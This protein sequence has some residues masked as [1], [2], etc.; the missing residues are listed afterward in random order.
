MDD[1][2]LKRSWIRH[3]NLKPFIDPVEA[4]IKIPPPP[5]A[6]VAVQPIK[7]IVQQIPTSEPAIS[8]V[9]TQSKL[10]H[11]IGNNSPPSVPYY[12]A[13]L[14]LAGPTV[15]YDIPKNVLNI[16]PSDQAFLEVPDMSPPKMPT[17]TPSSLGTKWTNIFPPLLV[18]PQSAD[19]PEVH[20]LH[21]LLH[22]LGHHP[23][24]SR[25]IMRTYS[26]VGAY[27]KIK[28]ARIADLE[29]DRGLRRKRTSSHFAA[30]GPGDSASDKSAE[31]GADD[32]RFRGSARYQA[33]TPAKWPDWVPRPQEVL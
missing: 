20:A 8:F 7:I 15:V 13:V 25:R 32:S 22:F 14:S 30:G 10:V 6:D 3:L 9:K 21:G 27:K 31:S 11:V 24:D 2:I 23:P 17:T 19:N 16:P 26:T 12:N 29:G 28:R 18:P 4:D 1:E 33:A 5:P